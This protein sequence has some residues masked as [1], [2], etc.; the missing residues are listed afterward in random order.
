[1]V[2]IR[3]FQSKGTQSRIESNLYELKTWLESSRI[4][5]FGFSWFDSELIRIKTSLKTT[6]AF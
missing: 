5:S 3:N 1:M 2:L 6:E 4:R